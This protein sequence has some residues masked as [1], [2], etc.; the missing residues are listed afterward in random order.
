VGEDNF[1]SLVTSK[2]WREELAALLLHSGL[3]PSKIPF[4]GIPKIVL[5]KY[6]Q[7]DLLE[8]WFF[9]GD[10]YAA[11]EYYDGKG[12][13]VPASIGKAI[14]KDHKPRKGGRHSLPEQ[15]AKQRSNNLAF[16]LAMEYLRETEPSLSQKAMGERV[17]QLLPDLNIGS[18]EAVIRIWKKEKQALETHQK[19]PT[20]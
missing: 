8:R 2:G 1:L 12:R 18:S 6:G 15:W 4:S 3:A 10:P 11:V 16:F 9:H 14:V 19:Q 5:E 20:P 7:P 13:D 17:R